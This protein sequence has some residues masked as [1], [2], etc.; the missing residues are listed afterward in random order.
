VSNEPNVKAVVTKV[1]LG[2]ADAGIAYVT[3]VTADVAQDISLIE[4]PDDKNVVAVYP[5]AVTSEAAE[6]DIAAAF[7]D[8]ILS[9]EGQAILQEHGFLSL[10]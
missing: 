9:D 7:I 10:G 6:P 8:F 2:E 3:D 5:V 1:Q 4:I